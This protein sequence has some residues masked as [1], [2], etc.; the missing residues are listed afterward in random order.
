MLRSIG[1]GATKSQITHGAFLSSHQLKPYLTLLEHKGLVI[2]DS[3]LQLY[4]ITEKG[5][6]FMDFEQY[7]RSLPDN[8]RENEDKIHHGPISLSRFVY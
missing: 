3:E 1:S 5:I 2:F 4:L 6:R 7:H 8:E